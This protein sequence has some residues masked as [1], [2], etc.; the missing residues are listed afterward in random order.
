MRV[1][2]EIEIDDAKADAY[3]AQ[4]YDPAHD[5]PIQGNG[6]SLVADVLRDVPGEFVSDVSGD[7]FGGDTWEEISS[8]ARASIDGDV[9][10]DWKAA[11]A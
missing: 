8:V 3:N 1:L 7:G 6:K 5:D 9:V 11:R 4:L 2:I 10:V